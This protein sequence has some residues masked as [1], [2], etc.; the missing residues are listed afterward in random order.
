MLSSLSL[1]SEEA[2]PS[3]SPASPT[4]PRVLIV[5]AGVVGL[6]TALALA[7]RGARV[8]LLD[9]G[10]PGAASS[11]LTGGGIRQ[12]FGTEAAVRLSLAAAPFWETFEARFGVDPLFRP[13]GYLFLANTQAEARALDRQVAL[14]SELGVDSERL[15]TSMLERR[16]PALAGRGFVA[17]AFRQA[18]GWANQHRI[19]DG[20]TRGAH[21]AG[22][23]VLAGA[24][25]LSL[26]IRGG[27]VGGVRTT[28]GELRGD[29]VVLATGA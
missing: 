3:S 27:R 12:Q 28:A 2:V 24:E 23:E 26:R 25:A 14:Q 11:T 22:V 4:A 19:L 21:A 20:L 15:D 8:T 9:R 6:C 29:A 17:A 16:W 7:A 18:D 5:G 10:L 1:L 13:I